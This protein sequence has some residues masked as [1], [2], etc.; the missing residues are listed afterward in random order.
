MGACCGKDKKG[1]CFDDNF[2]EAKVFRSAVG[3]KL[4]GK[5]KK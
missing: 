5:M 2:L 1:I 4:E 3:L